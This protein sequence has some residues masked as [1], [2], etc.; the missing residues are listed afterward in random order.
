MS[1]SGAE[2]QEDGS[3]QDIPSEEDDE[4]SDE[5]NDSDD[6]DLP[7]PEYNNDE[8]EV[9]CTT[10]A[11]AFLFAILI[12]TSYLSVYFHNGEIP[13][14]NYFNL[15]REYNLLAHCQCDNPQIR[16]T[17]AD[18]SN[19]RAIRLDGFE[20]FQ[21]AIEGHHDVLVVYMATWCKNSHIIRPMLHELL[22]N[23]RLT[24]H[25]VVAEVICGDGEWN[26]NC[27]DDDTL[28]THGVFPR[29]HWYSYNHTRSRKAFI[30]YTK[31]LLYLDPYVRN[32][33]QIPST[34]LWWVQ[35]AFEHSPVYDLPVYDRIRLYREEC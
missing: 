35:Y 31:L 19:P 6:D 25:L 15:N 12:L 14:R 7:F 20:E 23:E 18:I 5:D 30:L 24:K 3:W 21:D 17:M 27:M 10:K 16:P 33:Q 11:C 28:T 34:S 8:V 9:S 2:D 26:D 29:L 32:V 4:S 13:R 22:N 1:S